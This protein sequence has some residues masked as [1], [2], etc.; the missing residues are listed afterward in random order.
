MDI[1]SLSSL[2]LSQSSCFAPLFP[3]LPGFPPDLPAFTSDPPS[4]TTY[5]P[6]VPKRTGGPDLLSDGV[7]LGVSGSESDLLSTGGLGDSEG[8]SSE[9]GHGGVVSGSCGS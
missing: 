2:F 4:M 3:S 5:I 7:D 8:G 1:P 9:D 6:S